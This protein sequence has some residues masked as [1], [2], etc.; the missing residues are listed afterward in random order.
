MIIEHINISA[1]KQLLEQEKDF[2]CQLFNLSV[3][4]RPQFSRNGYWLYSNEQA[5]VHLTESN[6][7]QPNQS[8]GCLDHI[9]F[10]LTGLNQLLD[11]LAERNIEYTTDSLP[12]IGMTQVF[13]TSPSGV[14]LEANFLQ[15]KLDH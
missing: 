2:F 7:H 9:A 3:G 10:Q 6:L 14:G 8:Q 15:E 13:F 12:E 4:F 11:K 1:P 5:L